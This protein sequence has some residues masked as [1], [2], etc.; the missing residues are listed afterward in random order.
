MRLPAHVLCEERKDEN[1]EEGERE[2]ERVLTLF[3]V[4]RFLDGRQGLV[5]EDAAHLSD[6][7]V[8]FEAQTGNQEDVRGEGGRNKKDKET[9]P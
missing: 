4:S 1:E 7:W 5:C 3:D 8:C 9:K 6:V 2:R